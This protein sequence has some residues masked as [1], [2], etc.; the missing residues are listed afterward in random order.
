[1]NLQPAMRAAAFLGVV[2]HHRRLVAAGAQAGR[3]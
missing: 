1:V 3:D 2:E